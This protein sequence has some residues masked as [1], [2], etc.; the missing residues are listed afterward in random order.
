MR[1]MLT[2]IGIVIVLGA[3]G[4][5]GLSFWQRGQVWGWYQ[6]V[7]GY[8]PAKTPDEALEKFCKAVKD[9]DYETASEYCTGDLA[10]ELRRTAPA[11]RAMA[12]AIDNLKHN[13][14]Q[15]GVQSNKAKWVLNRLQPFPAD[16]KV[17]GIKKD[18][19]DR[20]VATLVEDYGSLTMVD[21]NDWSVDRPAFRGLCG[22][23]TG[24]FALGQP[25]NVELAREGGAWKIQMDITSDLR[26]GMAKVRDTYQNY[27][28][29]LDKVKY[30]I[31]RD[32][33]TKNDLEQRLKEEL[34]GAKPS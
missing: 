15:E 28:R 12:L 33:A 22:G 9:R 1:K 30:E 19:E 27:V 18:G 31:K 11:A 5:G 29:G 34:E 2:L 20:A 17:T 3:A 4:Y 7:R 16:V 25:V 23:L 21:W 13:M 6:A 8:G 24:K 10:L 14:D 32:A 26:F